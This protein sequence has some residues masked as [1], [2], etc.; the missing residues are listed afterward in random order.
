MV[1][2]SR[3]YLIPGPLL[4]V[5]ADRVSRFGQY[6]VARQL[7]TT[8]RRVM[9]LL[10]PDWRGDNETGLVKVDTADRY[11]TGLGARIASVYGELYELPMLENDWQGGECDRCGEHLRRKAP[12][13]GF[14]K[15]ER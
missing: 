11:L 10:R 15:A 2:A 3:G 12:L 8:E 6:A 4:E 5:L 7:G 14:C 9:A 1:I 13:C